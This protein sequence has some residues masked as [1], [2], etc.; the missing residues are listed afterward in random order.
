MLLRKRFPLFRNKYK[1]CGAVVFPISYYQLMRDDWWLSYQSF[2]NQAITTILVESIKCKGNIEWMCVLFNEG[3][4]LKSRTFFHL[5]IYCFPYCVY[6][7]FL[8]IM[9]ISC[10]WHLLRRSKCHVQQYVM[11]PLKVFKIRLLGSSNFGSSKAIRS[12][13]G[14]LNGAWCLHLA[15]VCQVSRLPVVLAPKIPFYTHFYDG[16]SF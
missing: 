8:F 16:T 7:S 5:V 1:K 4:K 15:D 14:T 6:D 12:C 2:H 10:P 9:D 3:V 13:I 11:L